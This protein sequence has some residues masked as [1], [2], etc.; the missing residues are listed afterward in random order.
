MVAVV[1]WRQCLHHLACCSVNSRH[2]GSESRFMPTPPA[3]DAPIRGVP[4]GISPSRLVWKN[5]NGVAARQWKISKISLFVLTQLTNV[6]DTQTDRH[7]THTA[8]QHKL[9][10]CIAS[11]GKNNEDNY[12]SNGT[13]ELSCIWL[14]LKALMTINVMSQTIH[15]HSLHGLCLTEMGSC[16]GLKQW[17][18]YGLQQLARELSNLSYIGDAHWDN[19]KY[20]LSAGRLR[21]LPRILGQEGKLK[22]D[23]ISALSSQYRSVTYDTPRLLISRSD[24]DRSSCFPSLSRGRRRRTPD[25]PVA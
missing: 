9:R 2:I 10:L 18:Y 17:L 4:V 1:H 3:F 22:N 15:Y 23:I 6:T 24:H 16:N 14:H 12:K 13:V 11:H 19:L 8:W 20:D 21:C 5:W 7:T 25:Q